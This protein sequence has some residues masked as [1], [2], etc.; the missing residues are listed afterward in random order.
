[1]SDRISGRIGGGLVSATISRPVPRSGKARHNVVATAALVGVMASAAF[2]AGFLLL[3]DLSL[4]EATTSPYQV[5]VNV[6]AALAFGGLAA[7]TPGLA[8]FIDVPRWT[9][10]VSAAACAGISAMAWSLATVAPHFTSYVSDQ[11]YL[12]FSPWLLLLPAPKMIFGLVGFV[13]VG[14]TGWRRRAIPRG[15]SILLVLA[16]VG[17]LWWAYPPGALLGALALAWIARAAE[18]NERSPSGDEEVAG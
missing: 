11:E 5:T 9:L 4:R 8:R 6:L 17:S 3:R 10:Y 15:A 2:I 7:A 13:A 18:S 16:G 14:V 1:M 12:E